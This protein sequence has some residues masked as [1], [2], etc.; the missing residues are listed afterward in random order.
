MQYR[1]DFSGSKTEFSEFLKNIFNN[2][3]SNYLTVEGQN[4][5]I[6]DDRELDYKIKY[7]TDDEESSIA[8]KVSWPKQVTLE[9]MDD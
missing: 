6:P 2:M 1:E 9:D 5:S 3:I 8:F 4:A 7:N